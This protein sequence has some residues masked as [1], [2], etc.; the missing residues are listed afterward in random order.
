MNNDEYRALVEAGPAVVMVAKA[1]MLKLLEQPGTLKQAARALTEAC[2]G[3]AKAAGWHN[4]PR[5]AEPRT[6]EQNHEMFPIRLMLIVSELS[7][8]ME[9]H[10]KS[11]MDDK[12]PHRKMAEVEIAD[13]AIRIFD[14]A[15]A[16]RYDLG[17]AIME[18]LAFNA[19]RA[20]HK[21]EN[22]LKP[23]GKAY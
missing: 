15:G 14:L 3:A 1:D 11:L 4:D 18:K 19:Q 23:G 20:D 16:M 5:T 8:A 2:Y 9:G 12:L 21:I 6:S 13:A 7:E 22:R 10:R 17:A